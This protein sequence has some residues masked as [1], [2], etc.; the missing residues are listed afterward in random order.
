[1]KTASGELVPTKGQTRVVGED[2]RGRN[3]A[4]KGTRVK[5]HKPLI[6]AARMVNLGW[7]HWMTS[8]GGYCIRRDSAV[9][10]KIAALLEEEASK[11]D[12]CGL[13]RLYEEFGVY[14]FYLRMGSDGGVKPVEAAGVQ[15]QPRA[16][17]APPDSRC[18][19]AA[20]GGG[21]ERAGTSER[22]FGR[23]PESW[24]PPRAR[25]G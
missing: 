19:S 13:L 18:R 11:P 23:H 10:K 24:S 12:A 8:G 6:S 5:C 16:R 20:S 15:K 22:P 21:A 3:W 7:D 1:M 17:S 4:L 14:N 25:P 2:D 9:A